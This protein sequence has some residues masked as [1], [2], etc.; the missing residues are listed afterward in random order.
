[1]EVERFATLAGG[2]IASRRMWLAAM[3]MFP[4][5]NRA[6]TSTKRFSSRP[7]SRCASKDWPLWETFIEHY[8]QKDGRVI[9]ASTPQKHT[10]SEGQSYAMF[11]ALVANDPKAFERLWR[12]TV[13]NLLSGQVKGRL[14]AWIWGLATDG[15]WRVLDDNSASDADLWL[16]YDL[17][18]AGRLWHREDYAQDAHNLMAEMQKREVLNLPGLGSMLLP[19]ERGFVHQ[20]GT[21]FHL[22]PSYLPIPLLRRLAVA[23]PSGPWAEIARNT[24]AMFNAV[25]KPQGFAPDWIAYMVGADGE[26]SFV[27]HP[28]KSDIG[29]YDAIR[30]YLW[31]G[32][33]ARSDPLSEPIVN[34]LHGLADATP[35]NSLPPESVSTATGATQGAGSF[36][37]AA[38]LL[39]YLQATHRREALIEQRQR[40]QDGLDQALSAESVAKRQPPYYDLVLTLFGRGWLDARYRFARTGALEPI[41]KKTPCHATDR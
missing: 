14:P 16:V 3:G 19:G 21:E 41:W 30:T 27:P 24:F 25:A 2:C 9:D 20:N 28:T 10:S 22:N 39:P 1:M 5:L 7:T 17:L 23:D 38:A 11:F 40:V 6:E 31:A 4:A 32:M 33:T 15:T 26:G 18:E 36:G 35:G 12:W 13:D 37:F 34:L 8:V 29:S